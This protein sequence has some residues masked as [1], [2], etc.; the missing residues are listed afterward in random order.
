MLLKSAAPYP[1]KDLLITGT[2]HTGP[3]RYRIRVLLEWDR[4]SGRILFRYQDFFSSRAYDM[5]GVVK[6]V[7]S[8]LRGTISFVWYPTS[9]V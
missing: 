8:D 5:S 6:S 9:V 3:E 2:D 4:I 7:F 1:V